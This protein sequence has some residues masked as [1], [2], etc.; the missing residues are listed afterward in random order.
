MNTQKDCFF[1]YSNFNKNNLANSTTQ[2]IIGE[3]TNVHGFHPFEQYN[4]RLFL[5]KERKTIQDFF[6]K[7]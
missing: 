5:K 2:K 7:I 4:P 6:K 3:I 1:L